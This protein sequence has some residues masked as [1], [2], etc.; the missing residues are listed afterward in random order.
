MDSDYVIVSSDDDEVRKND[1]GC[2]PARGERPAYLSEIE[3]LIDNNA[4]P[5]WAL[6]A[7]IHDT[8]ELAY[9]ERRA[10][11]ALTDFIRRRDEAWHVMPS[12]FGIATAW[13]AV[14]DSRK[15]GPVVSFNVEMGELQTAAPPTRPIGMRG[16]THKNMTPAQKMHLHGLKHFSWSAL[17]RR[18]SFPALASSSDEVRLIFFFCINAS[19]SLNFTPRITLT[20]HQIPSLNLTPTHHHRVTP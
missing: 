14:Y 6:N 10:H 3:S 11:H 16:T 15:P 20:V 13:I 4:R 19:P 12:A 7:F 17:I 9:R 8:P 5:L 2:G 1:F 18:T